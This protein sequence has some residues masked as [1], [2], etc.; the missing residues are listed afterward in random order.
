MG[1]YELLCVC[2]FG[3]HL[4]TDACHRPLSRLFVLNVPEERC[5]SRC[6]QRS[7]LREPPRAVSSQQMT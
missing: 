1:R 3:R 2:E 4:E 7:A 5:S 6:L